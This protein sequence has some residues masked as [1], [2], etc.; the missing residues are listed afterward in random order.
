MWMSLLTIF[1]F[2][3]RETHKNFSF[4]FC[5]SLYE[6]GKKLNK[7]K[8]DE[9]MWSNDGSGVENKSSIKVPFSL[10]LMKFSRQKLGGFCYTYT[11][12]TRKH[13]N[14]INCYSF[15]YGSLFSN[16]ASCFR[17][18]FIQFTES[19]E[20]N[21]HKRSKRTKR[22]EQNRTETNCKILINSNAEGKV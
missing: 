14:L 13:E 21:F 2:P 3:K 6:D 12:A 18:V 15:W 8:L 1:E 19:T 4:L 9:A 16:I 20:M 10:P 11:F 17:A 5:S 22:T 7:K